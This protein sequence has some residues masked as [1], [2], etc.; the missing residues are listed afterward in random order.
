MMQFSLRILWASLFLVSST[1][2]QLGT[3]FVPGCK[4]PF[5]S[6]RTA[7]D[8]RC[9]I[10]GSGTT[11]AKIAESKAKNNFCASAD[12]P[13]HISTDAFDDL[14]KA[15]DALEDDLTDRSSLQDLIT[16]NGHKV[17]EGTVVEF[18]AHVLDA[19]NSNTSGG[20]AVNCKIGGVAN[21]DIHIVLVQD[22]SEDPCK[23]VTAEMSPHFRP[24]GWKSTAVDG[25]GD[26]PIRVRGQLFFDSSH[27]P[28][29][30]K[31]RASPARRSV[32]EIHP[33]YSLDVCIKTDIEQ[34]RSGPEDDW[35]PIESWMG[36]EEE[37]MLLNPPLDLNNDRSSGCLLTEVPTWDKS[38]VR[39]R[40]EWRLN[41]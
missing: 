17:G 35:I 40:H 2:G 18:V 16:V 1:L 4:M 37:G 12:S 9:G 38:R 20:E 31:K 6:K 7:F 13:V 28:C 27:Q 5:E 26:H 36:D 8:Q 41:S 34:C 32:W 19:H 39:Q 25:V 14:Q 23:S 30:G 11:K 33:V 22:K 3:R 24:K 29:R 10:K 15:S 21:N